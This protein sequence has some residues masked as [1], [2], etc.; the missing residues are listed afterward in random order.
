MSFVG[1]LED[2]RLGELLQVLSLFRKSGK[3][4]ISH[5]DTTGVFLLNSGKMYHAANGFSAPS[6]GEY[7]L[8]R[9]LISRE[10]L[11]AALAT[12]RLAPERKK[13][14]AILVEMGA[15]SA[16]TL[17]Q[18]LRDQLQKIAKEFMKWDSGFFSFK[19]VEPGEES[20]EEIDDESAKL[21]EVVSIDPFI[22]D[23]LAKVDAVGGDGSVRPVP[24]LV[25]DGEDGDTVDVNLRSLLD[26]MVEPG[27]SVFRPDPSAEVT[28]WPSDPVSYTHIRA[29]ETTC[30]ISYADF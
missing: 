2:L 26:Y 17:D 20:Q 24:R 22:L 1:R 4:T 11:D 21:T 19:Q 14:G 12:Q 10:T 6:V 30:C 23:L 15:V 5:G 27:P 25:V 3:L 7:L 28:Q 18:V 9:K 13:L 16:E 8:S 29:H